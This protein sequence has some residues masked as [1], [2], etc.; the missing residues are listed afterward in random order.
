LNEQLKRLI[1]LQEVDARIFSITRL[2][3]SFPSKLAET[4]LPFRE[5]HDAFD[6]IKQQAASLERKKREKES[7][8][9]DINDKI[10]K[11]KSR[12]ADIKTNKEYQALLSEIDVIEKDRFSLED[13]ILVIM[14]EMDAALK[15]TTI[16][17]AKY[18]INKEKVD[19]L[20]KNIEQEK[21]EAEK[22]LKGF[23]ETRTGI[24]DTIDKE[25]YEQYINLTDVH[26][27]YVVVEAKE[28]ICQGCNMN[29][30]PQLFV[31]LKK[32]EDIV[33]CPQ[34]RRIL[35]FKNI[36]EPTKQ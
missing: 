26:A 16:E 15:Q 36:I 23:K 29:I 28:E 2:I 27:C 12:T 31:E 11:L 34:C 5:S 18:K 24:A 17:E 8:L 10:K 32:N 4:E 22:E 30:P 9:D 7:A 6:R 1:A 20:K 13:E 35:Y 19:A 14:E 33:H 21:L 25:I 3:D